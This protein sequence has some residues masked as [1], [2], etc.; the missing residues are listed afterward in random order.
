MKRFARWSLLSTR[1][2]QNTRIVLSDVDGTLLKGSLVLDH[3]CTLHNKGIIN[4]GDLPRSWISD[5]KNEHK[6]KELAQSYQKEIIGKTLE[7]M[8]VAEFINDLFNDETRFYSTINRIRAFLREGYSVHLISGSPT[9]LLDSFAERINRDFLSNVSSSPNVRNTNVRSSVEIPSEVKV[10]KVVGSTYHMTNG[11]F[12][13]KVDL[14]FT[15]KAKAEYVALLN[16]SKQQKQKQ[17][18]EVIAF[19]D[20]SS[21][22]PLFE[23]A[24]YRVLVDP[25]TETE[26]R[27]KD[28]IDEIVRI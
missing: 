23:A 13:G 4:L 11:K 6:I 7:D 5:P 8:N 16:L 22:I 18:A 25:T 24:T 10:I 12:N 9:Y 21:D 2:S 1:K 15:S 19:G 26:E 3:A 14:M 27:L 28:S 20:T 17:R